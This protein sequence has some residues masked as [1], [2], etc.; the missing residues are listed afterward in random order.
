M[1]EKRKIQGH[2]EFEIEIGE[3]VRVWKGDK[4]LQATYANNK[5]SYQLNH[6]KI[7]C[8]DL[9]LNT[10]PGI[11]KKDYIYAL[12]NGVPNKP[13]SQKRKIKIMTGLYLYQ[14]WGP[15]S[16]MLSSGSKYYG[17]MIKQ[18][19]RTTPI[20]E[21]EGLRFKKETYFATDE[22]IELVA[23]KVGEKLKEFDEKM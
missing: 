9:I 4:L 22:H 16:Y 11:R 19:Y 14:L 7:L 23:F 10:F 21:T 13:C 2:P 8:E 1:G 6:K 20:I 15:S 17:K 3:K 5:V 18:M 12:Y